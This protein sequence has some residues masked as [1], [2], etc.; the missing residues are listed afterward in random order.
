MNNERESKQLTII[1]AKK[2][3]TNNKG[4]IK[5][6]Y[7]ITIYQRQQKEKEEKDFIFNK[8]YYNIRCIYTR[9]ELIQNQQYLY[10]KVFKL[11][12]DPDNNKD[13]IFN[14]SFDIGGYTYT[15]SFNV[16]DRSFYFDIELTKVIKLLSLF[17]K[18]K[19]EQNSLNYYQ[20]LGLFIEALKQNKEEEKID[21]LYEE[22][23]KLCTKKNEFYL[24]IPLFINI[25]EKKILCLKLMQEFYQMNKYQKKESKLEIKDELKA[26]ASNFPKFL[27]KLI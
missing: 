24:L 19:V 5:E 11:F 6:I 27:L 13:N 3:E 17:T 16:D 8:N 10:A 14:I 23:I 1:E 15:I 21:N 18:K 26:Y 12:W 9:K 22:T 2:N 25:Y 4:K 20:K 7:F